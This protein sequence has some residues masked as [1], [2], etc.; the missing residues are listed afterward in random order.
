[1]SEIDNVGMSAAPSRLGCLVHPQT[2][3]RGRRPVWNVM[4]R[5]VWTN[6]GVF[7]REGGTKDVG[8]GT[9]LGSGEGS[10]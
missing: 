2:R 8:S 10:V 4:N 5:G 1:M 3:R 7:F 6:D 9:R